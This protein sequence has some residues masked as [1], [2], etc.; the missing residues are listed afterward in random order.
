MS[1]SIYDDCITEVFSRAYA[2]KEGLK[3]PFPSTTA[4]HTWG[5]QLLR[6]SDRDLATLSS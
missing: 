3:S 2:D 5:A 1:T 6:R 4:G